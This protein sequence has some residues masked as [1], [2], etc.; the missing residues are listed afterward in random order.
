MSKEDHYV[1]GM[2]YFSEDRLNDA[3]EE[4]Q[5]AVEEEP[6]YGDA[7]H[8]LAMCHY[9][10]GDLDR[11]VAVGEQ[12]RQAEP[13]NIHAYTSLSMFY[14]RKGLIPEAEKEQAKARMLNWKQELK[15][16]PN[17]PPPEPGMKVVQ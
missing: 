7:L 16:N 17:A 1:K 14:Q 13:K 3:I 11:A 10:Q 12:F 5:K 4:F 2:E 9:H 8:A 15:T 6:S